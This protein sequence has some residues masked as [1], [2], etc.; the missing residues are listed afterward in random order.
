MILSISNER[1]DIGETEIE[2]HMSQ[3]KEYIGTEILEIKDHLAASKLDNLETKD[4][5]LSL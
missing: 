3:L 4:T 5:L 2:N 1:L